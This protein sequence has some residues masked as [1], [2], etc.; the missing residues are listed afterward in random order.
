MATIPR[1]LAQEHVQ[2]LLKTFP[3]VAIVGPRQVGETTL[4]RQISLQFDDSHFFDLEDPRDLAR[5]SEASLALR[6]LSGLV[7]IDEI[8][9]REDLFPLLRVLAD[10]PEKPS[11]FLLLGSASPS[12]IARSSETLA[13]RI[14][15]VRLHGFSLDEV[16][17]KEVQALWL[18]GGFPRSFLAT[19]EA[20]SAEWR[21]QFISTYLQR[22]LP[23]L[24]INVAA[25]TMR[26]FWAMLA[27]YHAQTMNYSELGRS[28]N[29][30][31]PTVRRYLDILESTYVIRVLQPWHENL[32]KR[33][34][35]APKIYVEDSG[36]LHSLFGLESRIDVERHPKLGASW[37]GFALM[38]I[39]RHY[40]ERYEPYFWATHAGAE[41]DLLLV[42]G[43]ERL[44][45]EFKR[46][47]SPRTTKSMH[48]ALRDLRLDVLTI[49]HAGSGSYPL[50][51]YIMASSLADV[52]LSR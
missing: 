20:E 9:L 17:Q 27:H 32:A 7:V 14:A 31:D 45:F 24:G 28:M 25:P 52:V 5:L 15:Y 51:E 43:N 16:G 49:V 48:T 30:S 44:G 21:R 22:D 40:G 3:V 36:L 47:D 33:Q 35:K 46:T 13:G 1:T 37:E 26:R 41:L 10:R 4:A 11:K 12:L 42:R 6:P 2:S 19:T 50:T 23:Q 29:V 38:Q 39:L 8:Q 34:V 18:R